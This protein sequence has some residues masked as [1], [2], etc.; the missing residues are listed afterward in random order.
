[1][2]NEAI[3]EYV[4]SNISFYRE[5]KDGF[6]TLIPRRFPGGIKLVNSTAREII[7]LCNGSTSV[8]HI[9]EA[10]Q[11]RYPDAKPIVLKKDLQQTLLL[12][13]RSNLIKWKG[14]YN[15]FA[16]PK[17]LF[18]LRIDRNTRVYRAR[19]SDFFD[20]LAF[21]DSCGITTK[22]SRNIEYTNL[23]ESPLVRAGMYNEVLLR[24][25]LFS[26]I[27]RF[28][29]LEKGTLRTGM[30]GVME[31]YPISRRVF[32]SVLGLKEGQ[33]RCEDMKHI[34]ETV[35]LDMKKQHSKIKCSLLSSLKDLEVYR[36]CLCE[37]GFEQEGILKGEYIEGEDEFIYGRLL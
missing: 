19:E 16:L 13:S 1:M 7:D 26:Y 4:K 34:F 21:L 29:L 25:R 12:L 27:E 2:I 17:P 24:M 5:E 9:Y 20:I 37:I 11:Q 10:M 32:V 23:C 22:K 30:L 31:D 14:D 33:D 3:P 8:R 36:N 18:E 15:P 35:F 28:Y 6:V